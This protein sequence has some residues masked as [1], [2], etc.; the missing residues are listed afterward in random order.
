[1]LDSRKT[2]LMLL[3]I[4]T[5]AYEDL[6]QALETEKLLQGKEDEIADLR[7]EIV[8]LEQTLT[9]LHASNEELDELL[10]S[11]HPELRLPEKIKSLWQQSQNIQAALQ[12]AEHMIS[13]ME[14]ERLPSM[15]KAP[16][17]SALGEKP[18]AEVVKEIQKT[19]VSSV[20]GTIYDFGQSC[21]KG[22]PV[23]DTASRTDHTSRCLDRE[24]FSLELGRLLRTKF[25]LP[26]DD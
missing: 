19:T 9:N 4:L 26:L 7:F 21:V 24:D 14:M 25:G 1:M 17:P 8:S 16:T 6:V 10:K 13:K 5:G 15:A 12:N 2:T 18:S 23:A 20:L 11:F 22:C 3:Q